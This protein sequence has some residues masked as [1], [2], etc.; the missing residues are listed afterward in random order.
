VTTLVKKVS[1]VSGNTEGFTV[2]PRVDLKDI[3]IVPVVPKD[4]IDTELSCGTT[5]WNGFADTTQ[6]N[7]YVVQ[8][9]HY[10][11]TTSYEPR[12]W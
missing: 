3:F 1:H 9:P 5:K 7:P 12:K 10:D 4:R 2:Q 11:G 6:N 8:S